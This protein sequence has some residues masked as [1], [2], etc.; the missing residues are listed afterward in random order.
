SANHPSGKDHFGYSYDM[1]NSIEV[2]NSAIWSKNANA[3]MIW[4]DMLSSGRKLTG[5]GRSE[6]HTSELQ[7]LTNL[8]CRLLLEKK[9]EKLRSPQALT[10]KGLHD[11]RP[12]ATRPDRIPRRV[13]SAA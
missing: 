13:R 2:W 10:K 4:D 5:R 11:M 3:I 8:V 12:G 6:E 1:V 9:N 7:S